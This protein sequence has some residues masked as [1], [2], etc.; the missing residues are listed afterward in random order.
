MKENAEYMLE[1]Y[2]KLEWSIIPIH[3]LAEKWIG[4]RSRRH[5]R[6]LTRDTYMLT[7][8]G[9]GTFAIPDGKDFE[10][11]CA[12]SRITPEEV[13]A[14]AEAMAEAAIA[15]NKRL[16]EKGLDCF[17]LCSDYC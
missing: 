1:V 10:A 3:Y 9:D 17:I 7:T 2:S 16:I 14:Q 8:H 15:R 12:V 11:F 13:E 4:E 6:A 5:I